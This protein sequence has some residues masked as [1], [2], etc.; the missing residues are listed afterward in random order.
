MPGRDVAVDG[1]VRKDVRMD[2]WR[3]RG[4]GLGSVETAVRPITEAQ[5]V[6]IVKGDSK[7]II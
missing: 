6:R 4:R 1:R 2:G 7:Q 3:R 5:V